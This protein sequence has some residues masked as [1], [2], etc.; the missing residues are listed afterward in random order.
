MAATSASLHVLLCQHYWWAKGKG[1]GGQPF[2]GNVR[3]K[4]AAYPGGVGHGR[5][6][7]FLLLG[8]LPKRQQHQ[9]FLAL[10]VLPLCLL[11]RL[12]PA[13]T[14]SATLFGPEKAC[15]CRGARY[16]WI[17]SLPLSLLPQKKNRTLNPRLDLP[18]CLLGRLL[19][20]TTIG[21]LIA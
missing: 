15:Q 17:Y 2:I 8:L 1:G 10:A 14:I 5:H 11:D 20:A 7:R 18:H 16:R 3:V 12:L 6:L 13:E 19:P 9:V 4:S 21:N